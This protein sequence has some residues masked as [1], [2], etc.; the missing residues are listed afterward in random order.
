[1]M[2][3]KGDN[4]MK[5]NK[6]LSIFLLCHLI[7][8]SLLPIVLRPNLPMDSAEAL[9]WGFIGEWGTDKHPPLSGFFADIAYRLFQ[10]PAALYVLSQ[11]FVVGG[12]AYIYKLAKLFLPKAQALA[13]VL[14]LEGVAYYNFVTPEYN[15]NV[16]A[17]LLWPA[18]S[19]Y[20]Y[21]AV[22]QNKFADWCLFGI[23]AG[24]NIL[25]KYV[26]GILLLCLGL[27]LIFD[28]KGKKA[29]KSWKVYAAALIAFALITPHV[30]W[31]YRHD[32]FVLDYF[33][34]RSGEGKT[35]PFG[36]AHIAYPLKFLGA[37][38][39]S[40]ALALAVFFTVRRKSLKQDVLVSKQDR[41]FIFY[42]GVLPVLI[43]SVISLSLG[44]KLKSMWGSP[45]LY[46]LGIA[47]FVWFP[48]ERKK[49][50]GV[51]LKAGYTMLVLF[52]AAF[53]TQVMLTSS[54]KFKLNAADFVREVNGSRYAY[55]GGSVWLASTVGVYAD[56]HPQVLYFMD[57]TQN[58]W[59]DM[60]DLRQKGVLVVD[61]D[62]GAYQAYRQKF[63]GLSE[64]NV[65]ILTVK[66]PL[67]KT[68]QHQL[69]YGTIAGEQK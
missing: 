22:C 32:W 15:V 42:A 62:L 7:V 26:S 47:L 5:L 45:V 61:E 18:A 58:P 8:W 36:L 39:M 33:L 3:F 31:L 30:I 68:K 69:Y 52:A 60:N 27:Y 35:L 38:L 55:V 57:E 48:F 50:D 4:I 59:I 13:S 2:F 63:K 19:Y 44:I 40:S 43:M 66:T 28:K 67:G 6:S 12:L 56:T 65:Y 14:V 46:M 51:F 23:F 54:A 53:F 21:K 37:Q 9:V 24:L 20:F 11:F 17:L 25:N 10:S 49:L 34:S 16:I 1:M 29:L 41:T 64:P